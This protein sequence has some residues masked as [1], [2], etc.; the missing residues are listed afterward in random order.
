MQHCT[1]L[2]KPF[3]SA[4]GNILV[5]L[6]P[7][8]VLLGG[9]LTQRLPHWELATYAFYENVLPILGCL[10][11]SVTYHTFMANHERYRCWLAIDVRYYISL[12]CTFTTGNAHALILSPD[13]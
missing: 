7:A 4:A 6:L 13:L 3:L 9:L 2:D 10:A 5:H 8:L 1:T 11:G 12:L